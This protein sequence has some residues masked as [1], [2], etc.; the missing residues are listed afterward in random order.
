MTSSKQFR[1]DDT[2]NATL[3]YCSVACNNTPGCLCWSYPSSGIRDD[4]GEATVF[5][6]ACNALIEY[7]FEVNNLLVI[8]SSSKLKQH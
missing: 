8:I 5:Y 1:S 2:I 6:S 7:D 4:F 3:E